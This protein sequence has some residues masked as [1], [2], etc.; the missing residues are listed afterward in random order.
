MKKILITGIKGFLGS[1]LIESLSDYEVFGL[2]TKREFYQNVQ[3]YNS[4]DLQNL[5]FDIDIVIICHAAVASGNIIISND[6]LYEVN[7]SLTE[8]IISK[9]SNAFVIYISTTSVYDINSGLITEESKISPQS[10]YAF[11]KLWAERIVFQSKKSAVLRISSLFGEGM[12]ENTLIPNYVNQALL[13]RKILVWGLGDRRQNFIY[14]K[15][16]VKY[17]RLMI[18]FQEKVYG[19]IILGVSKKEYSNLEIAK[20]ISDETKAEIN[21]VNEDNSKSVSYDNKVSTDL[22]GWAP[23]V[24]IEEGL[25]KYIE[26]KEKKY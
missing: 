19:K 20:I 1:N 26:W 5:D 4:I 22:L 2:G 8:R 15:D 25:K 11:S 13:S 23:K 14:V 3:V 6:I 18:N 9:F 24:N 7:V 21:F 16:V 10:N 12:K 17:I